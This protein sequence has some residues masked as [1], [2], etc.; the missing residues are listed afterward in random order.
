MI[1]TE[2]FNEEGELVKFVEFTV[3]E[4]YAVARWVMDTL[5]LIW[6]ET[7]PNFE[8]LLR[9]IIHRK[10]RGK[11]I[12]I[13]HVY[14]LQNKLERC[15]GNKG[16]SQ[17]PKIRN[18]GRITAPIDI[19]GADAVA[20]INKTISDIWYEVWSEHKHM[21]RGVGM[22][23]FPGREPDAEFIELQYKREEKF[24]LEVDRRQ[25]EYGCSRRESIVAVSDHMQR[26]D[27]DYQLPDPILDD[28]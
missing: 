27:T 17:F 9:D 20:W 7:Y 6:I 21:R 1:E 15:Q 13:E 18:G 23:V 8:T 14:D 5:S 28:L 4:E 2:R 16:L 12:T 22:Q 11:D 24:W 10:S 25:A 19:H 3:D 26:A